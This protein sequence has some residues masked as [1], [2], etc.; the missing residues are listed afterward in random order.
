MIHGERRLTMFGWLS[1]L[2]TSIS[3]HTLL[4]F[5][6]TFFFGITFSATSTVIAPSCFPRACPFPLL[7]PFVCI[8]D[9]KLDA[10]PFAELYDEPRLAVLFERAGFG[11]SSGGPVGERE[12]EECCA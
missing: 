9:R 6:F 4:S 8:R 10:C 1:P 11:W 2:R 7:C 5:P 12:R 3:L